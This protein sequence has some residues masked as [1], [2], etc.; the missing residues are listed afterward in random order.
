MEAMGRVS[1]HYVVSQG[2]PKSIFKTHV[3]IAIFLYYN[4]T[5]LITAL[6]V[7]T[8][9]YKWMQL[10]GIVR[11]QAGK[12]GRHGFHISNFVI[13]IFELCDSHFKFQSDRDPLD[14]SGSG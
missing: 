9:G 7:R 3:T 8:S 14:K 6:K 12:G 11:D 4:L 5:F 1:R 13:G 2:I 10:S